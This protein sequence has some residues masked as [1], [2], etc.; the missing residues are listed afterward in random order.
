L[1]VAVETLDR[2]LLR[3]PVPAENLDRLGRMPPG[4]SRREQLRLRPGLGMRLAALLQLRRAVHEQSR[5]V[6]LRRHIRELPLDR[7]ELADPLS[8]LTP[9]E[10]VRARDVVRD[11]CDPD[12]LRSDPD[13]AA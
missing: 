1:R 4:D 7:V 3:V 13:P 2:E 5:R 10:R 6:D 12:R 11:L 9:L 8:E